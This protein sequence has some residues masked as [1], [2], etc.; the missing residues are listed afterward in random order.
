MMIWFIILEAAVIFNT[1]LQLLKILF[2]A[3]QRINVDDTWFL[4]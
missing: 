4:S 3:V 2:R 1:I